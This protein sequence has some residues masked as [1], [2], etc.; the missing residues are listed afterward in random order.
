MGAYHALRRVCPEKCMLTTIMVEPYA[1]HNTEC[2][3]NGLSEIRS[4]GGIGIE[5]EA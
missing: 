1:E 3:T 4:G 2:N 5:W